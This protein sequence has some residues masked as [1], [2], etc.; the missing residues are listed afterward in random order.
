[1]G[2]TIDP[3]T[4]ID[5]DRPTDLLLPPRST[6]DRSMGTAIDPVTEIDTNRSGD[7]LLPPRS[8]ADRSMGIEFAARLHQEARH[9]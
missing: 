1:M 9:V 8:T 5:N 6:A 2:T 3:V 7:L 4:E